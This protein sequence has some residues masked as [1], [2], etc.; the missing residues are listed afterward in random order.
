[1]YSRIRYSF[2]K[3]VTSHQLVSPASCGECLIIVHMSN[4][5]GLFMYR[6]DSLRGTSVYPIQVWAP[7]GQIVQLSTTWGETHPTMTIEDLKSLEEIGKEEKEEEEVT[8]TVC[9]VKTLVDSLTD[10][11][12]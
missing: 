9:D 2:S 4:Y 12:Q 10:V 1:M 8:V 7:T 6:G 3:T 11:G 5:R